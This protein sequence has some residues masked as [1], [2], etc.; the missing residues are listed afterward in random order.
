MPIQQMMTPVCAVA[1]KNLQF[2]VKLSQDCLLIGGSGRREVISQKSGGPADLGALATVGTQR[3]PVTR[4]L[5]RGICAQMPS[6]YMETVNL[7]VCRALLEEVLRRGKETGL[8]CSGLFCV[9]FLRGRDTK[10]GCLLNL[11]P[12]VNQG[13]NSIDM[14]FNSVTKD[15]AGRRTGIVDHAQLHNDGSEQFGR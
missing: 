7:G 2:P 14:V 3:Q 4:N 5:R 12:P 8:S 15:R 11:V 9:E 13:P 1:L 6:K 10:R